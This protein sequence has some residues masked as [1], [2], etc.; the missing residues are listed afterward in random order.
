MFWNILGDINLVDAVRDL[1]VP[2]MSSFHSHL[3]RKFVT[4]HIAEMLQIAQRSS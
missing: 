3:A 4:F 1:P 2:W